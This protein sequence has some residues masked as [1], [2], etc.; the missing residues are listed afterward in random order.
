[1]NRFEY[2][3][4][5]NASDADHQ[6]LGHTDLSDASTFQGDIGSGLGKLSKKH[7]ELGEKFREILT[8]TKKEEAEQTEVDGEKLN[9]SWHSSPIQH[10]YNPQYTVAA[11]ES[12][13]EQNDAHGTAAEPVA[14]NLAQVSK[15][16]QAEATSDTRGTASPWTILT[17]MR[18]WFGKETTDGKGNESDKDL[19]SQRISDDPN[20]AVP[21]IFGKNAP[22]NRPFVSD[23]LNFAV[24]NI[25]GKNAPDNR[26]FAMLLFPEELKETGL[27]G[28][29]P[30]LGLELFMKF[31][32][33]FKKLNTQTNASREI[34]EECYAAL[35][36]ILNDTSLT[37]G[38]D[39]EYLTHYESASALSKWL[40]YATLPTNETSCKYSMAGT[41]K[42]NFS[43]D[44]LNDLK[45][46]YSK[47]GFLTCGDRKL[48]NR[49]IA[50]ELCAIFSPQPKEI[51]S[52]LKKDGDY[53]CLTSG[54]ASPSKGHCAHIILERRDGKIYAHEMNAGAG[55]APGERVKGSIY[56]TRITPG[57]TVEFSTEKDALSFIACNFEL[58]R[59][60]VNKSSAKR[61]EEYVSMW[62]Q[63]GKAVPKPSLAGRPRFTEYLQRSGNCTIKS[64]D[65]LV[66]TVLQCIMGRKL[67]EDVND[68]KVV[69]ESNKLY[70]SYAIYSRVQLIENSL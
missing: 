66:R 29:S 17:T 35:N 63:F 9:Y 37:A 15:E 11:K 34:L 8:S 32:D 14:H 44:V 64:T 58:Q 41:N 26:P 16:D 42:P 68:P 1:M 23:D 22:D 51:L 45:N 54:W 65:I 56:E 53:T 28:W 52:R 61:E 49:R 38:L 5:K 43:Q 10:V 20:F 6:N 60:D 62:T 24:P 33:G 46:L 31:I 30:V 21:N 4:G 55:T 70:R 67:G 2:D 50:I 40:Y 36:G 19:P 13:L 69:Q 59:M 7:D 12:Q 25:F 18:S 47:S 27:E 39:H 57:R 48:V 3:H